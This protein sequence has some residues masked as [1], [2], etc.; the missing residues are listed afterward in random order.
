MTRINLFN[1]IVCDD[2]PV[3]RFG[4]SSLLRNVPYI[5]KVEEANNGKEILKILEH[6]FYD[7][8]FIEYQMQN[9]IE[10]IHKI[11]RVHP[12]VKV[13]TVLMNEKNIYENDILQCGAHGFLLKNCDLS[14][15][16]KSLGDVCTGKTY[17]SLNVLN[18]ISFHNAD[19]VK[20]KKTSLKDKNTL[21]IM[22]LMY[23]EKT[24]KEIARLLNLSS[25]TVENYRMK[26]LRKTNSEN[27]IGIIKHVLENG[28]HKDELLNKRFGKYC[29]KK[30]H[31]MVDYIR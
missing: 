21:A 4:L 11:I 7:I 29:L 20:L 12:K 13:I 28:I 19:I 8:V 9:T 2:S 15:I 14:E 22:F 6:H 17:Y 25:R 24:S 31:Q 1:A 10:V 26:F 16:I 23:H 5:K 30:N 27:M 3:F 18:L